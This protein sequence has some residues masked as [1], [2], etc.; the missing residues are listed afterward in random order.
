MRTA[1]ILL[2]AA[3]LGLNGGHVQAQDAARR[4]LAEE[5]LNE[6]HMKE[7]IEKT[8][9][10]IKKI[11]PAQMKAFE[12]KAGKEGKENQPSSGTKLSDRTKA[13]NKVMDEVA[14]EMSWEKMKDDYISLYAETFTEEE[15]KGI[16]AFLKSPAGRALTKKQPELTIRTMELLQKRLSRL[17]PKIQALNLNER[18]ESSH[19][20]AKRAAPPAKEPPPAKELPPATEAAPPATAPLIESK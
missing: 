8:L 11:M 3:G 18:I 15:L 13:M 17:I 10:M 2:M 9:A 1:I 7:N 4:A 16:I 6:M 5:L 14:Q 12:P 20:D 19:K